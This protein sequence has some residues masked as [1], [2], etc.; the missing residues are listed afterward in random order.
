[1][2]LHSTTLPGERSSEACYYARHARLA[3]GPRVVKY[4]RKDRADDASSLKKC[5]VEMEALAR[6]DH[7]RIV[8]VTDSGEL[9]DGTPFLLMHYVRSVQAAR[10]WSR[11]STSA[12]P[13]W[14]I[15]NLS[16]CREL[17][18][19]PLIESLEVPQQGST[20]TALPILVLS[21]FFPESNF[22]T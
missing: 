14:T 9:A 21:P 18:R 16:E 1:M 3:H 12:L 22:L 5:R 13:A 20:R 15:V 19:A 10:T 8:N 4:L 11:S 7:P 6:I 2:D 17:C